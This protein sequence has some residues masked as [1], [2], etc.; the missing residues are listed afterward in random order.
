MV[1]GNDFNND[2]NNSFTYNYLAQLLIL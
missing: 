1:P 2:E